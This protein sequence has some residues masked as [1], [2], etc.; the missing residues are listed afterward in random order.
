MNNSISKFQQNRDI[1]VFH[2]FRSIGAKFEVIS[3]LPVPT[4]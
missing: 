3:I 4:K 1:A 2:D